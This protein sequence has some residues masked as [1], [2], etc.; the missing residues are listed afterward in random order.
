MTTALTPAMQRALTVYKETGSLQG[1]R[2]N[3]RK[4]LERRGLVNTTSETIGVQRPNR[5]QLNW[6]DASFQ[7]TPTRDTGQADYSYWDRAIHCLI[8]GLEIAGLLLKPLQSKKAA[9]VMGLA[10][11]FK[12]KRPKTQQLYS[13]WFAKHQPDVI[14]AYEEAVGKADSY[15]VVNPPDENGDLPLTV[16][17]PN[18]VMPIVDENDYS[19]KLG[20]RITQVYAHPTRVADTMTIVDEYMADKRIRKLYKGGQLIERQEFKNLLGRIPVIKLSH[21]RGSDEEFGHPVGEALIAS[22]KAYG[23]VIIAGI[24]GNIKQ[25][26]PTPVF[27]KMG[28]INQIMAW[29]SHFGHE[30]EFFLPDGSKDSKWVLDL[31]SDDAL[32]LGGDA[33]FKY[34]Q[35]GLF[36][37]DTIAIL[38][39]LY[40][41]YIEHTEF[42]EFIMGTAIQSSHASADAQMPPF[43]KFIQKN[44]GEALYWMIE[45]ANV[46]IAYYSLFEA[47]VSADD[48]VTIQWQKLTGV[49]GKLTLDAIKLGLDKGLIDKE[50]ALILMPLDIDDPKAVLAKVEA[51]IEAERERQQQED[52]Q[53]FGD[54]EL[55]NDLTNADQQGNPANPNNQQEALNR[56]LKTV[57]EAEHTSAM[58]AFMLDKTAAENLL[59]AVE[60]AE[61]ENITPAKE[62]HLTL[63]ILGKTADLDVTEEDV[64]QALGDFAQGEFSL[65]GTISGIGLFTNNDDSAV[66][67]LYASFD[68]PDLPA[69]RQALVDHLAEKGIATNAD[70]G[71]TPHITLAY[72]PADQPI[73]D[74]QLPE[75]QLVFDQLT[76]AWGDNLSQFELKGEAVLA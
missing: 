46:V 43:E 20:Y 14:R 1:V 34:A 55:S 3:T 65:R 6:Y 31:S 63:A 11:K 61:V 72:L 21:D 54:V 52:Q 57:S 64:M 36:S 50:T 40:W 28:D 49:D 32:T 15:L 67:P 59:S 74:I 4:A 25:G 76:L 73:P 58:I 45:L 60:E 27:E 26:R 69:F 37:A 68:C 39:L 75:L 22:L 70:H 12:F 66:N 10:P 53:R 48:P 62:M 56:Y 47:G 18:V 38:G 7:V 24:Q 33:T 19:R 17:P 5:M 16:I 71:F 2:P 44:Q 13:E 35:P 8:P 41:L 42:P 30:E 23:D 9:W 29:W 51:E